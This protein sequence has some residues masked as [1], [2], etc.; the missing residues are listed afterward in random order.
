VGPVEAKVRADLAALVTTHPMGE[1]LTA[2]AIHLAA[3]VDGPSFEP[4]APIAKELRATLAELARL[5]V[6]DDTVD[7]S[8]PVR[9][10]TDAV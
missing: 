5:G 2:L 3:K 4:T 6:E 7:L 1:S 8:T 10:A 9:N